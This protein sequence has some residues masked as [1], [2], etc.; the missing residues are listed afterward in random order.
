MSKVTTMLIAS[1]AERLNQGTH[2]PYDAQRGDRNLASLQ[3]QRDVDA[4]DITR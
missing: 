4:E 3:Q 1:A 2:I